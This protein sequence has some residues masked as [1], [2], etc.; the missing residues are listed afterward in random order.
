MFFS[1]HYV[2]SISMG[3]S[4]FNLKKIV[5][6]EIAS[7]FGVGTKQWQTAQCYNDHT[8]YLN[9]PPESVWNTVTI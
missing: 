7:V 6:F 9:K 1:M 8:P 5:S 2:S 3:N 4:A